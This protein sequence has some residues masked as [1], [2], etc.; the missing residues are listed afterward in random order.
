MGNR[1]NY[2]EELDQELVEILKDYKRKRLIDSLMGPVVSFG[3]HLFLLIALVIILD[4][5]IDKP[6]EDKTVVNI[7]LP[8]D[9]DLDPEIPTEV[10]IPDLASVDTAPTV[11]NIP[12][13]VTK[14]D[15]TD[16]TEDIPIMKDVDIPISD[17]KL[18]GVVGP[19]VPGLIGRTEKDKFVSSSA[20][21]QIAVKRVLNWLKVT[22]HESGYWP[23]NSDPMSVNHH[24]PAITS[25]ALL[26]YFAN[27]KTPVSEEYGEVIENALYWLISNI[28]E[29][30]GLIKI[31]VTG[32]NAGAYEN[33]LACY[34]ISEAYS[35]TNISSFKTLM[36]KMVTAII[37]AQ[38]PSG[39]WS[40]KYSPGTHSDTS[41]AGWHL[42]AL[43]AA[44]AAGCRVDGLLEC[45]NRGNEANMKAIISSGNK[46]GWGYYKVEEQASAKRS[47]GS[48]SALCLQLLGESRHKSVK[49]VFNRIKK[50][51]KNPELS[52]KFFSY[53]NPCANM[54]YT[55][56]YQ[57]Q[58]VFQMQDH[59]FWKKWDQKILKGEI[60]KNQTI[61]KVG[62]LSV[63]YWTPVKPSWHVN[64]E[65]GTYYE[66]CLYALTLQ[67]YYRIMPSLNKKFALKDEKERK[68]IFSVDVDDG[69][70]E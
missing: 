57:S 50:D 2:H 24:T 18:S 7:E 62:D 21:S 42:Q 68:D 5:A 45:I 28:D 14:V 59:T 54:P 38:R 47:I 51:F 67:V 12:I 30:T 19:S 49:A 55:W 6:I 60:T 63:G 58:V 31:G 23:K 3:F 8:P 48:V 53:D 10:D 37:K 70:L 52:K 43:K 4:G 61:D 16:N 25:L 29:E 9:F 26:T 35:M 65:Y 46:E 66:T 1:E 15:I 69:L 56:Y 22:Q 39:S 32:A 20:P 17:I 36:D 33:A 41:I 27:G 40:Y 64:K 44:S 13:E 34:A 11:D